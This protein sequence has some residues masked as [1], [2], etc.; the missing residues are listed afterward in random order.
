MQIES[1]SM[2]T[3]EFP[4]KSL[5]REE[6]RM[7]RPQKIFAGRKILCGYNLCSGL[8]FSISSILGNYLLLLFRTKRAQEIL[9]VTLEINYE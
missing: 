6:F 2:V 8:E 1:A 5:I 7:F 9:N 4:K 3:L